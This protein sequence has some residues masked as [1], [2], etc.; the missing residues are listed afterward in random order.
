MIRRL[1]ERYGWAFALVFAWKL[2]L[3]IFTAQPV[4]ANDSYFYDGAVV[5]YLNGGG[6][7]NPS[8]VLA[9]PISSSK[10]FSAYPPLYQVVLLG[11]MRV[12]GTTALAAMWLHLV[13][14]GLYLLV[15]LRVFHRLNIPAIWVNV[16][17]L[18]LFVITFQDRPDSLAH[19]LGVAAVLAWI[20]SRDVPSGA[21]GG[22][23]SWLAALLVVLSLSTSLQLGGV[24]LCWIWLLAFL[25]IIT[26]KER[27]PWAPLTM[28]LLVP[29]ALIAFVKLEFPLLWA[30]FQE[31]AS[32]TP[33][34][35]GWRWPG[36]N[37]CLKVLRTGPGVF[38]VLVL[39]AWLSM[40]HR[41]RLSNHLVSVPALL[42][43]S[44]AA[45]AVGI[46]LVSL[47]FLTPNFALAIGYIQPLVVGGFLAAY[48]GEL[49][50]LKHQRNW[51]YAFVVLAGLGE[52][53]AVGMSTWGV[54]CAADFSHAQAMQRVRESL[55]QTPSGAMVVVSAAFLYE[56]AKHK[57]L[58]A[59]HSDWLAPGH[60][61]EPLVSLIRDHRP[62][63]L[64]LTQF[65]YYRHFEDAVQQ[66]QM[67]KQQVAVR[68]N[69][70]AKIP[71]PDASRR[72]QKVVQHVSWAPVIVALKWH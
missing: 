28:T 12:F 4:P 66:L 20:C 16:A 18:F 32:Q 23:W 9:L 5:N 6:Y 64:I 55:A 1:A 10:V 33:S 65:D 57:D 36:V 38:G 3:L 25:A 29:A 72:W 46:A 15:L 40:W 26:Q 24:Y 47:V 17:G 37:D 63:K 22:P 48:G 35:V 13:L 2:A 44:G 43:L 68:I 61:E 59:I 21:L 41:R 27:I 70:T 45:A 49:A 56:A 19:L 8:L 11:W 54:A 62:A 34:V 31:H 50:A 42:A 51:I 7:F 14:F 71:V 58:R 67:L 52:V 39:G 30:G 53:R 60:T 69:D